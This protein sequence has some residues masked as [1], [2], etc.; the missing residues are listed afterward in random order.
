MRKARSRQSFFPR[1]KIFLSIVLFL[2]F[3]ITTRL[4]YWQI[5]QAKTLKQQIENQ[6]YRQV[7]HQGSRGQIYTSDN[8]LLVGNQDKYNL[9]ANPR[10]ITADKSQLADQIA[11]ILYQDIYE[12]LEEEV[13]PK[14]KEVK[15]KIL[16]KLNKDAQWISLH[17]NISEETKEKINSLSLHAIGFDT[18]STRFYPEASMA[19]HITGFVGKDQNGYDLGYFGIEGA[20]NKELLG[21][22]K[23][24][25]FKAD[26]LGSLL[27]GQNISSNVN[28]DGRDVYLTIRRDLQYTI[29]TLLDKGMK[30]YGAK[31]GEI[32]ILEPKTGKV[33]ALAALPRYDQL[34]YNDFEASFYKNPGLVQTYEPGSTF[35]TITVAAALDAGV[36]TP[37]TVCTHCSGPRTIG[38]Y[39]LKTWNEEYH[40]NI[41][42]TDALA[43][44]DNVAMIFV[45][46]LLGQEK[47][48]EYLKKFGIGEPIKIDLQEDTPTPFRRKWG[49]VE[50]ATASFGQGISTTSMQLIRAVSAIANQ[51]LMMRPTIL[52]K[53]YDHQAEKEILIKPHAERQ[54]IEP[55]TASLM[56]QMMINSAHHGEA[57][58]IVSKHHTVAAK[59]GTSQI[60]KESGGG[61]YED[62]TIASFIGF[63]PPED[64]QFIMLV[65]LVEPSSSP[66]AAETAAPLWYGVA[67]KIFLLLNIPPDRE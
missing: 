45:S 52:E 38:K 65:K 12:P 26:A 46:E 23:K 6:S 30:K 64:P 55:K 10:D 9:F 5:I 1:E 7:K 51:G 56:A 2:F 25:F 27:A 53:V 66:W 20:L 14:L 8:F 59:T 19:A 48:I 33:L 42:V 50:L 36:V 54:V 4:F 67:E 32:I 11:A 61:Y 49:P 3:F 57:Q 24:E 28:V 40:P 41:T 16:E 21:K 18:Y 63:A 15:D 47:F 35:K 43:K 22:T 13:R 60:P 62:K 17:R 58:W 37:D 29:E 34:N 31:A 44:S 39:T